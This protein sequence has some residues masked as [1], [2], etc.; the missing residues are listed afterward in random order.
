MDENIRQEF[1]AIPIFTHNSWGDSYNSSGLVRRYAN[2]FLHN[3]RLL[4]QTRKVLK[5]TGP[6]DVVLLT[7]VRIYHLM[8]WRLLSK[9]YL[10]KYFNRVILFQL[11][12]EA[13]YDPSYQSFTFKK[14]ALL[15]KNV[16][17][18]F[19]KE[20]ENK[21]VILAGD[22]HVTANEYSTLA[23]VPFRVF[24]SPVMGLNVAITKQES[25][26][27]APV[28]F[29]LLGVSFID[30][31]IDVLQEAVLLLLEKEPQLNALF[32][33]QWSMQ[34]IDF[35]GNPV[36]IDE[37]LRKSDKVKLLENV[38]TEQEY[39]EYMQQSDFIVLP[40]RRSIYFNRL[41]GV[42][43]EAATAGIAMIVTENT[44]LSWAMDEFGAGVTVRDGDSK[45]LA[46]KILYCVNHKKR[47]TTFASERKLVAWEKN[48]SER[49][50]EC[51]W[52]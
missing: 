23:G 44:W 38:L 34:T 50:L 4:R 52:N 45:D 28:V 10:G 8:A 6:V 15:I 22:S 20:I 48:S 31:G 51:V 35:D 25:S 47:L 24:P 12:S 17:S 26:E 11:M 30:K 32:V 16:L 1:N 13:I 40:Y 29:T 5:Q 36:L 21:R 46:E 7:S 2:V 42:A 33:I 41:S 14:T 3:W 9:L 27:F 43:I 39:K 49:Y 19:K 18:G 37:R